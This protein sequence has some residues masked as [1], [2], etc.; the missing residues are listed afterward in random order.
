MP[1]KRIALFLIM[2]TLGGKLFSQKQ[3]ADFGLIFGGA[4]PLCDYT[5]TNLIK[6]VN[7]DFGAFYRYNYSSRLSLRINAMYGSV[8]AKGELN[9]IPQTPF[10]KNVFDFDALFEVNYLDFMMGVKEMKFSPYVYTGLGV[11]YYPGPNGS[12]IVTP[13][14]PIGVGIKYSLNKYF[15][16][17]VDASLHKLLNDRLD[18]L[19]NPYQSNGLIKVNDIWHNNDWIIY[20]GLTLTYKF[21]RGSKPC[22]AY[23]T[24]N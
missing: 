15:S 13:N 24:I 17:G 3:T 1:L 14:I 4:T 11:T 19:E 12:A 9:G 5:Q 23:N 6:S 20:F 18:N 21:Y 16:A 7:F 8:G 22:P 2:I 10:K